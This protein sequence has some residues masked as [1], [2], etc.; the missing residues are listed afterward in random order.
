[1]C[2]VNFNS[3]AAKHPSRRRNISKQALMGHFKGAVF[4][5]AIFHPLHQCPSVLI[6]PCKKE[7]FNN[8]NTVVAESGRSVV[9]SSVT[10]SFLRRIFLRLVIL[11]YQ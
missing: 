5:D 1:M 10:S 8:I 3:S 6:T 11:I 4:N 2:V 7:L 9:A